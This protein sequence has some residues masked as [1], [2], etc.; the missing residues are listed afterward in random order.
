MMSVCSFHSLMNDRPCTYQWP[1]QIHTEPSWKSISPLAIDAF[2]TLSCVHTN[3]SL[4]FKLEATPC[5]NPWAAVTRAD[6][7]SDGVMLSWSCEQV[8]CRLF[9][10]RRHNQLKMATGHPEQTLTGWLKEANCLVGECLC[11]C[12]VWSVNTLQH[13]QN[14]KLDTQSQLK[15]T[16]ISLDYT[17]SAFKNSDITY[18]RLRVKT[19]F[20]SHHSFF[21]TS[22][23]ALFCPFMLVHQLFMMVYFTG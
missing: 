1:L 15:S 14:V 9:Q 17:H 5:L 22:V 4:Q 23:F 18:K 2:Y 3:A 12:G 21:C 20:T 11:L 19:W 8:L 13:P 16:L 7:T 10:M 6:S